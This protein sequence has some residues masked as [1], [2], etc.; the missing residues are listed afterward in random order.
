[1]SRIKMEQ[2]FIVVHHAMPKAADGGADVGLQGRI[3]RSSAR[4]L[5]EAGP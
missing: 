2:L 1:M 5:S 4:K 3:L